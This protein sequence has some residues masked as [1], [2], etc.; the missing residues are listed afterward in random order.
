MIP[1]TPTS[2]QTPSSSS[3]ADVGEIRRD[4]HQ[5][6]LGSR[7]I[8]EGNS[9]PTRSAVSSSRRWPAVLQRAQSR[10]VRRADVDREVVAVLVEPAQRDHVVLDRLLSSGVTF[11][12]P[13]EIPSGYPSGPVRRQ[14][15]GQRRRAEVVEPHPVDHGL[16]PRPAGTAAASRCPAAACAVTVPTSTNPNPSERQAGSATPFL[17]IPAAS[18]TGAREP[19]PE[20]GPRRTGRQRAVRRR[21]S[22]G[23]AP[24]TRPSRRNPCSVCSCAT[25]ASPLPSRYSTGRIRLRYTRSGLRRSI[26]TPDPRHPV[27]QGPD[28]DVAGSAGPRSPVP[29]PPAPAPW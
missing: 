28:A 10:R 21:D 22:A 25:S 29:R 7:P 2:V 24:G 11:D 6:R 18:P 27:L 4:L 19:H 17:S 14:P 1:A 9:P 26:R 20:D 12:F 23:T 16:A 3:I 8:A 5:D 15:L 13:I